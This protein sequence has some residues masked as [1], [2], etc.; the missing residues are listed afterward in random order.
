MYFTLWRIPKL[1]GGMTASVM[2][3]ADGFIRYGDPRSVTILTFDHR[4]NAKTGKANLDHNGYTTVGVRN[5]WDDIAGMSDDQL[6]SVFT[7]TSPETVLPDTPG[8]LQDDTKA[9]RRIRDAGGRVIREEHLREDGTVLFTDARPTGGP[10]R[11]VMHDSHGAP[12]VEVDDVHD[13]YRQW[14]RSAVDEDPA[15]LVADPGIVAN[16]VHSLG[17]RRFKLVHFLHVSHLEKPDGG[18]FGEYVKARVDAFRDFDQFD[19]VAVQ[20]QKQIDDMARMGLDSDRMRLIPSEISSDAIAD[21]AEPREETKGLVA[22]R[23]VSLKQ[24]DHTIT[25]AAQALKTCP[26]LTLDICGTG[27][28][29]NHLQRQIDD[30]DLAEKVKL[31]GHVHD[32]TDRLAQA[33]FSLLTSKHEGFGL[34]IVESMAAGCIPIAY[35]IKYGPGGIITHGVNGFLVPANDV[36][37]LAT[38]IVEFLALSEREKK[39]MREAAVSRA[40]DFLPESSYLRWKTALESPLPTRAPAD[41]EPRRRVQVNGIGL[42]ADLD[43]VELE[44]VLADR[45]QIGPKELQLLVSHRA[46]HIFFQTV[47]TPSSQQPTGLG[48]ACKFTLDRELFS[49]SSGQT[50]DVYVRT[51]GAMWTSKSRLKLP[52]TFT[53]IDTHDLRWYRTKH[54]NLSVK[55]LDS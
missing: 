35:D 34:A 9:Y 29:S 21:S 1:F 39:T 37:A 44:I 43:T 18:V 2:R 50:F 17:Q 40:R 28:E 8:E 14:I 16:I 22:G 26:G 52:P 27:P 11:I 47:G 32:L 15:V 53:R 24:I 13:F 12:I 7:G 38:Q 25:A 23:L 6:I 41:S 30:L 36:D 55:V 51:R 46:K 31:R 48:V 19:I 10:R 42:A 3:R 4:Q 45:G 49:S 54:G 5:M 33:S 20:T